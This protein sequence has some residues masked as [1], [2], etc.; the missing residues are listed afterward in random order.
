M[1]VRR[2][3]LLVALISLIALWLACGNYYRPVA[4]PVIPTQ[5][6]PNFLHV[7]VVLSDNG[8]NNSGASTTIDVSGDSNISQASVG[9]IPVHAA[10]VASGTRV[11]VANRLDDTVSEVSPAAPTPV[12][13]ISLPTGSNPVFVNTT[14]I[15]NLYVANAGNNTV[16]I[17]SVFNNVVVNTLT[18]GTNPVSL[19]ETPNAQELYVANAG[20]TTVAGSVSSINPVDQTVN[21]PIV[22]SAGAPWVSPVWAL[23]RSDSQRVYILDKGS[24][25]VSAINTT[26]NAVVGTA[27]V[28]VGADYMAYD[29]N[30]NRIYVTNPVA[31]TLTSL[32]VTTDALTASTAEVP[33]AVAVAALP[34]G[35]RI[36]V[37]STAISNSVVTSQ[38]T[39]LR[40]A[41]LSVKAIVPLATVSTQPACATRTWSE[42]S[43]AAAADSTR[44]YAANC[45]AGNISIIQTSNDTL[46]L[47]MPAPL[48]AQ[49]PANPGGVPPPQ[50]PVFVV[51]GP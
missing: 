19:A 11:Y 27:S 41:D 40:T 2:V 38:V 50:N 25:F 32:D 33:N 31:G 34:D 36:Y 47:Q 26:T 6:N 12:T 30:L 24:G 20:N 14:E 29:P 44:V 35:T 42:L 46:A 9:L 3:L 51:A 15:A 37:S 18:V 23:A 43:V 10:I 21:P 16:S 48:S 7:A 22:A 13:T 5:P 45:D 8:T 39:V 4:T 28:G 49:K 17:V 1:R